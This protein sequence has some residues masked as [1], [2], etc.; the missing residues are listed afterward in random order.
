MKILVC[1]KPLNNTRGINSYDLFA[2]EEALL[3][4][5]A[6]TAGTGLP[7][8]VDVI[9][10]TSEEGAAVVRRAFGMGAD[11]AIHVL[12]EDTG[13]VSAFTTASR[14]VTAL[15]HF[16]YDMILTGIMSED[17][18]EGETGPVLAE[19]LGIPCATG[20]VKTQFSQ[21]GSRVIVEREMENGFRD[22]IEIKLPVLLAVQPGINIPRYPS[23]TNMLAAGE[24]SILTLAAG[25]AAGAC[26]SDKFQVSLNDP[27]KTRAGCMVNGELAEQADQLL[28][29]LQQKDLT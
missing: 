19:M 2:L 16:S 9:T 17:Q 12:A 27:E 4:K 15:K 6:R 21:D 5:E 23:L 20:V 25:E 18:M 3:I 7:A 13:Y 10:C 24:K 29:F 28:S 1:I 8:E 26:S 22:V 11:S 14:L